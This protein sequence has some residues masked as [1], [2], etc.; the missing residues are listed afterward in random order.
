V[1]VLSLTTA[2][3]FGPSMTGSVD[4]QSPEILLG[5]AAIYISGRRSGN[6][7]AADRDVNL[8]PQARTRA[9]GAN[10]PSL[11]NWRGSGSV[12]ATH[13]LGAVIVTP[14]L[15]VSVIDLV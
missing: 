11:E 2:D 6:G 7:Q 5:A 10:R 1:T 4:D 12:E 13:G 3:A 14:V 15:P 9:C 8:L